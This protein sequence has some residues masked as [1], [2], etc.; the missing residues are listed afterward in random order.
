[1][2]PKRTHG[3]CTCVP[4]KDFLPGG[5]VH[6]DHQPDCPSIYPAQQEPDALTKLVRH[7]REAHIIRAADHVQWRDDALSLISEAREEQRKR[8]VLARTDGLG[9]A[10]RIAH[11]I[12]RK[13]NGYPERQK[14]A[15][16]IAT[17]IIEATDQ[18]P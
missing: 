12:A 4:R 2:T 13:A 9:R 18:E 15:L 3:P 5:G 17:L 16:D 6:F 11:D 10:A 7:I 14:A 1:M 8:D